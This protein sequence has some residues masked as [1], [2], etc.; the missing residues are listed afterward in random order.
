MSAP[1]DFPVTWTCADDERL[2]WVHDA[3]H[4]PDPMPPLAYSIAGDA[5]AQGLL[6]AAQAYE[7]PILDVRV[8]RI[9]TYRYQAIIPLPS[10]TEVAAVREKRS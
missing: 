3:V 10:D 1:P 5:L 6:A 7:L 2:V 9:N 8:R 4:W